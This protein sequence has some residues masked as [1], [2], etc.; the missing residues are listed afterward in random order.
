MIE[1]SDAAI[2]Y[3]YNICTEKDRYK[4][5]IACHKDARE[6]YYKKLL[7]IIEANNVARIFQGDIYF[8]NGSLIRFIFP[9]ETARGNRAH[10]LMVGDGICDEV[11]HQ[12]LCPME[13]LRYVKD[14]TTI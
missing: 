7:S 10:L 5:I 2:A 4:V 11:L 6:Y 3:A 13:T 8:K 14:E 12:V 1:L 9:S